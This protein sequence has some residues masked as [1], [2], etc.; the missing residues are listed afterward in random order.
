M[1][2]PH[3]E[4]LKA[5]LQKTGEDRLSGMVE[6]AL[7]GSEQDLAAFLI[8]NELWGGAG[9]IADEAGCQ[10]GRAAQ[11]LIEATLIKLGE[12]Q[13]QEGTVNERTVMWVDTFRQWQRYGI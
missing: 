7:S 13:I 5:V 10:K 1:L 2:R 9:S 3:V 11:K 8:S 6:N 4:A 12:Q